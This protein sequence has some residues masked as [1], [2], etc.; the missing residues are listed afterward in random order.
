MF[1]VHIYLYV[2]THIFIYIRTNSLLT[3]QLIKHR[4]RKLL[5]ALGTEGLHVPCRIAT[6]MTAESWD[7]F[8]GGFR[9]GD[10]LGTSY[11]IY[12]MDYNGFLWG[13]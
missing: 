5:Y 1:Y 10:M 2:H 13:L 11:I 8:Q 9:H 6:Q 4:P 3:N 12:D 7:I